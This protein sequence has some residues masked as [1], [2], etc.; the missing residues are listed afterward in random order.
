MNIRFGKFSIMSVN[1]VWGDLSGVSLFFVS[2]S[3][4]WFYTQTEFRYKQADM[5]STCTVK[6]WQQPL[7]PCSSSRVSHSSPIGGRNAILLL[8]LLVVVFQPL[9]CQNKVAAQRAIGV[10]QFYCVPSCFTKW[11]LHEFTALM[12]SFHCMTSAYQ[13][14]AVYGE[15]I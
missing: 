7:L 8:L 5:Y 4:W 3:A 14:N 2:M 1:S 10:P 11:G 6:L 13:N 12:F 15:N 9:K